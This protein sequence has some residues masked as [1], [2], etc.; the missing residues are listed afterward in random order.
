MLSIDSMVQIRVGL[1]ERNFIIRFKEVSFEQ[2]DGLHTF[3]HL[4][5]VRNRSPDNVLGCFLY[6]ADSI[7]CD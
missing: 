6:Q 1:S 7:K 4:K 2:K 3:G 5:V